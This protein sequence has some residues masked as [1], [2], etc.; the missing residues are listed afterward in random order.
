MTQKEQHRN[1]PCVS[2]LQLNSNDLYFGSFESQSKGVALH[3]NKG[4]KANRFGR[5]LFTRIY[6]ITKQENRNALKS[7]HTKPFTIAS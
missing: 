2:Y 1:E 7:T 5:D 4:T 3:H 6:G